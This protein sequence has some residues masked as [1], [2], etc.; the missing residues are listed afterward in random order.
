MVMVVLSRIPKRGSIQLFL[1]LLLGGCLVAPRSMAQQPHDTQ[2]SITA[3]DLARLSSPPAG[4]NVHPTPSSTAHHAELPEA[5]R[6]LPA[7]APPFDS[8]RLT[9]STSLDDETASLDPPKL[10]FYASTAIAI[11]NAMRTH[12]PSSHLSHSDDAAPADAAELVR[13]LEEPW[14]YE[15]YHWSGLIAQSLFFNVFESSWR[16]ASDDQIRR[17]VARKPFWH[18]YFA[19]IRQFNMGRWND[20]DPFIVNYVGHPM[21]GAVAAYIEIQNDPTGRQQEISATRDYWMSR[22]KGFLWATVFSTHSEIS[23]LGEAGIGNEGGWTYPV[24]DCHRPCAIWNPKTMHYTNNTGWVDFII[25]PTVGMLW[26]MA[27]DT[28]DRYVSDRIQGDRRSAAFPLILRG[29]LNPSRTMANAMRFKLPWYRDFQHGLPAHY[30]LAPQRKP[31]YGIHMLP[32]DDEIPAPMRRFSVSAHYRAMPLGSMNMPC[33]ICVASHGAGLEADYAITRWIRASV[34]FDKQGGLITPKQLAGSEASGAPDA[35]GST[36]IAGFGVR[37]VYDRPHNTFSLAI[38][39][40]LVR[41]Q[42]YIPAH[43]NTLQSRYQEPSEFSV[44]HTAAS[45]MLANDYKINRRFAVRSSFGAL[46][47]RYRT[48]LRDPDGVGEPPYITFLSKD[49]FTNHTSWIW[50]GGPVF[51]F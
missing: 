46:V 43:V 7:I 28:L 16:M 26:V 37:L 50:Q 19:S 40:G 21:Q 11:Q 18:D 12:M 27:E 39:P 17:L 42:F 1:C 38:R 51:H 24:A 2:D 8:M 34:S 3:E 25:T 6:K 44:T 47:V 13:Q 10:A 22:F 23:P 31:G 30:D 41:D 29:A 14:R 15:K 36:V 49:N 4:Q 33:A 32:G 35:T 48:P 9:S 45:L 5:P 20:G